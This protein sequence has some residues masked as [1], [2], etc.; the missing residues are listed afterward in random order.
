VTALSYKPPI[1]LTRILPFAI[2]V[3]ACAWTYMSRTP[4]DWTSLTWAII[5]T[6]FG[7]AVMAW[8]LSKGLWRVADVVTDHG[9]SIVVTRR[10]TTVTVPIGNIKSVRRIGRSVT[11]ALANPIDRT[12]ADLAMRVESQYST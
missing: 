10:A 8:N 5:W 4:R 3:A 12:I 2:V 9:D 7:S 1:L 6:V 11:L